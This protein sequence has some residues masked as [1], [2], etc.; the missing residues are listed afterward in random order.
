MT[1]FLDLTPPDANQIIEKCRVFLDIT[2]YNRIDCRFTEW[3]KKLPAQGRG[4]YLIHDQHGQVYIGKGIAKVRTEK[5]E[6]KITDTRKHGQPEPTGW[7]WLRLVKQ[8]D[9]TNWNLTVLYLDSKSAETAL[10]GCL[11]HFLQPVVND[12]TFVGVFPPEM[13]LDDNMYDETKELS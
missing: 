13:L 2:I 7:K 3:R 6:Q 11:I 4:V 5:H 10:E 12:E 1:D 8:P 9:I